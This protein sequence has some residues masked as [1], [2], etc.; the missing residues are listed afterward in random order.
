PGGIGG[1][2]Y[3][4]YLLHKKSLLPPKRI[5]GAIF[6]DRLCGLWAVLLMAVI[7][8]FFIPKTAI[9]VE[10]LVIIFVTG[11]LIYFVVL[12]RYFNIISRHF[13]LNHL[14]AVA[15]QLLQVTS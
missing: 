15:V 1:D 5:F 6:F 9:R 12:Q 11:T 7:L 2:G 14:K 10:W 13:I 4:I 8:F 3:K